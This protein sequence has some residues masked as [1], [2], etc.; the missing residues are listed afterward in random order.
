MSA[1]HGISPL[2]LGTGLRARHIGLLHTP[3]V[4]EVVPTRWVGSKMGV[5]H[6]SPI[7]QA[8][9]YRVPGQERMKWSRLG[10]HPGTTALPHPQD[11]GCG[12]PRAGRVEL[13][14]VP[15][16]S[17]QRFPHSLLQHQWALRGLR[18]PSCTYKG[19]GPA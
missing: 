13:T 19:P 7:P 15:K 6:R 8:W 12:D 9:G 16:H 17:L 18:Q 10:I 11:Q 5:R 3:G 14:Q 4:G 2:G 1:G